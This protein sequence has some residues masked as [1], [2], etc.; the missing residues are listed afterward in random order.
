M[1]RRA[2]G[3]DYQIALDTAWPNFNTGVGRHTPIDN[4]A[5]MV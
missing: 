3:D 4:H 2:R 5:G 1:R